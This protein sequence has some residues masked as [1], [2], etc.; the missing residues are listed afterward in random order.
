MWKALR[1]STKREREN[2]TIREIEK[3]EREYLTA[4]EVATVL[5]CRP[6]A[7]RVTAHQQPEL[8]GFPVSVIGSRVKIPRIAFLRFMRGERTEN[9]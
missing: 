4:D 9:E 6:H 1:K 5:C 8:L 3:L 2:V 7:I